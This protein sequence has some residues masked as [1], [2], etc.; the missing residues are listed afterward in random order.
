[1]QNALLHFPEQVAVDAMKCHPESRHSFSQ[2]QG[3]LV[4][5]RNCH[6]WGS[7]LALWTNIFIP[8]L[9]TQ[10]NPYLVDAKIERQSLLASNLETSAEPFQLQAP[11]G[12]AGASVENTL[13]FSFSLCHPA[14]C[15][16]LQMDTTPYASYM[17]ISTPERFSGSSSTDEIMEVPDYKFLI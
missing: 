16:L 2:V 15:H 3:M 7:Y 14:S 11:V 5:D 13:Q 10:P 12:W 6:L 8:S 4:V 1:M 17:Q 9:W